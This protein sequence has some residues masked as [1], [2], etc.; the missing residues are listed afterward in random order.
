MQGSHEINSL[1]MEDRIGQ[2]QETREKRA[3]RECF[4]TKLC[5]NETTQEKTFQGHVKQVWKIWSQSVRLMGK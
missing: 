5:R 2:K 4:S 1:V 3:R